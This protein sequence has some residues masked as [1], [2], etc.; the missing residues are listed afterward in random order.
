MR[1][2]QRLAGVIVLAM[3]PMLSGCF[4]FYTTRH[5]PVPKAPAV[6]QTV[7][8][9]ELVQRLNDRWT[10]LPDVWRSAAVT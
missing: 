8:P 6:I 10:P 5:L 9:D 4:L 1:Y 2:L 7:T 3:T